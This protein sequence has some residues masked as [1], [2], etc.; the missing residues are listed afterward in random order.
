MSAGGP[1]LLEVERLDAGYGPLQILY[2]VS[3]QVHDGEQL[4]VFGPNGAGKST[5]M[6]ALVGLASVTAGEA[7][8]AGRRLTGLPTEAVVRLGIGYVPQISNVFGSMTVEENLEMGGA[9]LGRR[10]SRRIRDLFE[11]FPLLAERRRQQARTLSGGQR[12]VL[13]MARALMPEPELLL[14]DEP[15]AGLSPG[16]V[17][18][19][20]ETVTDICRAGTSVLMVEQNARQALEHVDRGVVLENGSVR[21]EGPA[22]QLLQREDIGAL[23]LG[24]QKEG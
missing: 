15:S 14:L 4:L 12:Q 21:F 22:R 19:I 2:Q 3:L 20:F 13:A 23:Y 9:Q 8:L 7:R 24:V 18:F 6:K 17:R 1:V 5:L 10:V 11:L 16:M